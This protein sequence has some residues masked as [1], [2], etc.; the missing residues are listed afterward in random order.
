MIEQTEISETMESLQ[1]ESFESLKHSIDKVVKQA[2]NLDPYDPKFEELLKF[3]REKQTLENNKILLFSTFLHT[4]DYIHK[5]LEENGFRVGLINGSIP[6][7]ERVDLRERFSLDKSNGS[8]IDILLS[9]EVGCEGLDYQFCDCIVNYDIPWNPMR[10]EQRIG[11]IDRY[12][13]KSEAVIICNFVT[14]GTI[15]ADIYER[16]LLRI[17]IFRRALGG[18]EEI[19]GEINQKIRSVAENLALTEEERRAQL[20]Q[21]ADNQIRKIQEQEELEDKQSELFSIKLSSEQLEKEISDSSSF[22]L[23]PTALENLVEHYLEKKF[24]RDRFVIGEKQPKTLRL[25]QQE[26]NSL[27][28]DYKQISRKS[29]PINREWEK[30]LKG[31]KPYLKV[32][33]DSDAASNFRDTV[34][35]QPTHPLI[36][37][38]AKALGD[39]LQFKTACRVQ[40]TKVPPGKYSFAIYLWDKRGGNES[41]SFQPVCEDDSITSVLLDL[42]GNSSSI[43]LSGVTLPTQ[44]VYDALDKHHYRL[45]SAARV[46]HR[47]NSRQVAQLKRESLQT[48]HKARVTIL[49]DQLDLVREERIRRMRSTQIENANADFD[50]RM[51]EIDELE[52]RADIISKPVAYGVI[53]VEG[54]NGD[55]I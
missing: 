55:N 21:I 33:F 37:Q 22:W 5:K 6:D 35:V 48:S 47:A 11:R 42:L 18:S 28:E 8:A 19:L 39:K 2:K 15:D 23:S 44:A 26:R 41:M 14:P 45:W 32:S 7:E 30:W 13:Q 29:S 54:E 50:R 40:S 24:E 38:A 49:K 53:F 20:Q 52:S 27:L 12:G 31:T 10:I 3:I 51:K 43:S 46:E 9:S 4:L 36:Q 34:F 16:C 25:N 17:G 1:D